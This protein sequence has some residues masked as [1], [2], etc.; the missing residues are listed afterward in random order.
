VE[1]KLRIGVTC[2]AS[3][4]GSGV[5]ATELGMRT[6]ARGHEV[7][8]VCVERPVRLH[9][10]ERLDSTLFF[11]R[12]EAS[13][14]PVFQHPPMTLALAAKMVEV[15]ETHNLDVLHVHYALPHATAAYLAKQILAEKG[16]EIVT[17]TTLHGTDI[18][19]VGM[20]PA[21][22]DVTRFSISASDRVTAVSRWLETRTREIFKFGGVIDVIPNFVDTDHFH[23]VASHP[24]RGRFASAGEKIVLH[25]SNFRPVKNV[26][27]VIDV[28]AGVAS[29]VPAR[30][31]LLGEGPERRAA[32]ERAREHRISDRVLFLGNHQFVEHFISLADLFLL[33]SWHESFGLAAL[34]AMSAG[35]PVLV[36][37]VGGAPEVITNGVDGY[38][39]DPRDVPEMIAISRRILTDPE[40]ARALSERGRET[41]IRDYSP[42]LAVDRYLALYDHLLSKPSSEKRRADDLSARY[43]T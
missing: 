4:G 36:T 29:H 37:N 21:I 42:E 14:Y 30:L 31:L 12:A 33:P 40:H 20:H 41:A 25:S 13:D 35:V 38:V 24:M 19:L 27:A 8:F 39:V 10:D 34:E 16:K 9:G 11:H 6:A 7:H 5:L 15:A 1:R 23:P 32:E 2:L 28:F 22:F 43:E 26:Q 17:V 18:T 3:A